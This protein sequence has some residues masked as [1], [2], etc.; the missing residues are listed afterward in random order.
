MKILLL[1]PVLLLGGCRTAPVVVPSVPA[2]VSQAAPLPGP[3]HDERWEER[4]RQQR[5]V[6]EALLSQNEA[7]RAQLAEIRAAKAAPL[8]E[9]LEPA[10]E[11]RREPE[12]AD[13]IPEAI[14]AGP[15]GAV[16]LVALVVA[17]VDA[18]T[19]PFVVRQAAEK[20]ARET[21]LTAHGIIRG[22]TTAALVN[23]QLLSEGET[24]A[25]FQLKRIEAGA[26]VFERGKAL[27][28]VRVNGVPVRIKHT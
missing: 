16:D 4:L 23:G 17:E 13:P 22:A 26:L 20:A 28:R 9:K 25:G 6:S 3:A 27:V 5:A 21:V 11:R 8:P 1:M 7:L 19:N 24:I 18:N 14:E 15:D 10:K 12:P 2:P